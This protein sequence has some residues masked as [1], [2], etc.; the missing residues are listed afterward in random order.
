[1]D[2][3]T[4]VTA[5]S[6]HTA[7]M[8][9]SP[10]DFGSAR[11]LA[12]A[13]S[14]APGEYGAGNEWVML[15]VLPGVSMTM[16]R[17]AADGTGVQAARSSNALPLTSNDVYGTGVAS[18]G[19][20]TISTTFEA[21]T[22]VTISEGLIGGAMASLGPNCGA[23]YLPPSDFDLERCN[24]MIIAMSTNGLW[25]REAVSSGHG[26]LLLAASEGSKSNSMGA[27]HSMYP[28]ASAQGRELTDVLGSFSNETVHGCAM[29][30]TSSEGCRA[31]EFQPVLGSPASDPMQL[32]RGA[33][34]LFMSEV[35]IRPV[36]DDPVSHRGGVVGV[37][38]GN[39]SYH[40]DSM[41]VTAR[42]TLLQQDIMKVLPPS[43]RN[44]L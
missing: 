43:S 2:E 24:E 23:S 18:T 27:C 25:M 1:M 33:C 36:G 10:S 8:V 38:N 9:S 28:G 4:R 39:V 12:L 40:D 19:I 17:I 30:C 32:P 6:V 37:C 42:R 11:Y 7:S 35:Y 44:E 31:F 34:H 29:Q 22:R 21:S 15:G 13:R 14:A 16:F 3:V 5:G 26:L 20:L 41:V